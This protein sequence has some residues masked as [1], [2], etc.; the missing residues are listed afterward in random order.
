MTCEDCGRKFNN[1]DSYVVGE[2]GET[3][4]C[5]HIIDNEVVITKTDGN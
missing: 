2:D 5:C 4:R 1:G 3:L